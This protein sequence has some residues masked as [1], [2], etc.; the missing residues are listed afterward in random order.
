MGGE[1]IAERIARVL[2]NDGADYEGWET[3][4]TR[5]WP[6]PESLG[7]DVIR[8]VYDDGSA[9]ID[10]G[11]FWYVEGDV[12]ESVLKEVYPEMGVSRDGHV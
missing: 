8:Y 4:L 10:A 2:G 1:S 12:D 5:Q 6:S 9:I 11:A 3:M 7:C